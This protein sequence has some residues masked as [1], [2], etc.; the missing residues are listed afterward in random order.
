MSASRG[1][2]PRARAIPTEILM[3]I[4]IHGAESDQQMGA[5][6]LALNSSLR[7][8][9]APVV[10]ARIELYT[11]T[12][13]ARFAELVRTRPEAA[14]AVRRLWIGP[15]S[16][17][18][19]LLTILSLPSVRDSPYLAEVREQ[20]Y[21]DTR[22]ILR[23]CRR[24]YDVALSGSLVAS[25]VVQ[26]YG[27]ACQPRHVTS[28]NAHSFISAFDAPMFR[29][30]ESLTVCDLNLSQSEAEAIR[31][32]PA[33]RTFHYT[34]PKD[35]GDSV[36]DVHVLRKVLTDDADLPLEDAIARMRLNTAPL[37]HL[38]VRA[39]AERAEDIARA[40]Y[41]CTDSATRH[42]H[43][44]TES[45]P[46]SFVHEWDALRDLLFHAQDEYARMAVDDD[47][48]TDVDPGQPLVHLLHEWRARCSAD[49]THAPSA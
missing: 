30:V 4:L 15:H 45:L 10:Y 23:A 22:I 34:T 26:S 46:I 3:R 11:A 39:T 21:V 8:A 27:T 6:F 43:I 5:R 40:L 37:A 18:S 49:I 33:L 41:N 25:D 14:R 38:I 42:A 19:D 2:P 28:I 16:A 29:R 47:T 20:T 36:R 12:A 9:L 24:L 17:R 1:A 13:I 7:A 31:R 35:Y 44:S 32:M 48:G